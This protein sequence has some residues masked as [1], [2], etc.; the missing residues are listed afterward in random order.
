MHDMCVVHT[1]A[2]GG[3]RLPDAPTFIGAMDS[4]QRLAEIDCF[5]A[6]RIIETTRHAQR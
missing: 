4:V 6:Q 1:E 5:G 3:G 2:T